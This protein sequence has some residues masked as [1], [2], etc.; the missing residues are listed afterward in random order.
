MRCMNFI[1]SSINTIYGG[2]R[3]ST[4]ITRAFKPQYHMRHIH[5]HMF[6][7][8][9][10]YSRSRTSRLEAKNQ[11]VFKSAPIRHLFQSII[12]INNMQKSIMQKQSAAV[13][14]V[15]IR[16]RTPCIVLRASPSDPATP[17]APPPPP[18]EPKIF[19]SE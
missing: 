17:A 6:L 16:G 8:A 3:S 12:S 14:G 9:T 11:R 10:E 18:P 1:H 4:R 2:T 7:R 15:A 19:Y 5:G 13:R